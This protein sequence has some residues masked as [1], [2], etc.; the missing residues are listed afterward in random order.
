[1][2]NFFSRSKRA[3]AS[4]LTGVAS[5][6]ASRL[7]E[8]AGKALPDGMPL[9]TL[10]G[11]A[12]APSEFASSEGVLP[13]LIWHADRICAYGMN[14]ESGL[15]PAFIGE[16][17]ALLGY[18][19]DVNGSSAPE[20][21]VLLFLME[22]VHQTFAGLDRDPTNGVTIRLDGLVAEFSAAMSA[23]NLQPS[24]AGRPSVRA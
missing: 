4:N 7:A 13:A 14:R 16:R 18:R 2:L 8:Q 10:G 17:K 15:E 5:M 22:S 12:L 24:T 9:M 20:T 6:L 23:E 19:V 11:K 3:D 1:M 21:E